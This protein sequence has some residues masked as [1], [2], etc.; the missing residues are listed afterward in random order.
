MPPLS[1]SV[2]NSSSDNEPRTPTSEP[3]PTGATTPLGAPPAYSGSMRSAKRSS[4]AARHNTQ[5]GTALRP[6]DVGNG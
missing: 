2:E 5:N 4:Y 6:A 1:T 3:S